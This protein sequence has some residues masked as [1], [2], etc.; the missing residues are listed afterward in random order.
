[1]ISSRPTLWID[2][3]LQA[4]AMMVEVTGQFVATN[5]ALE[6]WSKKVNCQSN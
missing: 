6:F 1:M 2:E 4:T 5:L 3:I